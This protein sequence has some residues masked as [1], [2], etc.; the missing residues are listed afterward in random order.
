MCVNK[1]K[2][3]MITKNKIE[4]NQD[5]YWSK[6]LILQDK[7]F[8]RLCLLSLFIKINFLIQLNDNRNRYTLNWLNKIK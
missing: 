6:Y 7:I 2:S 5:R 8:I 1:K 4:K 3:W